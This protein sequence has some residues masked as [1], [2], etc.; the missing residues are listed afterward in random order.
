MFSRVLLPLGSCPD[1]FHGTRYNHGKLQGKQKSSLPSRQIKT[2]AETKQ[3]NPAASGADGGVKSKAQ[4]KAAA[5]T[6]C[7]REKTDDTGNLSDDGYDIVD[8]NSEH[9]YVWI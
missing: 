8:S 5:E 1:P 4:S 7:V 9:D 2:R 6:K 3:R